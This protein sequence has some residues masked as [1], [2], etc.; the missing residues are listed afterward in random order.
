MRNSLAATMAGVEGICVLETGRRQA[1]EKIF[2]DCENFHLLAGR[3]WLLCRPASEG[4][5]RDA[6]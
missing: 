6:G 2:E 4:V 1:F 5:E 3:K